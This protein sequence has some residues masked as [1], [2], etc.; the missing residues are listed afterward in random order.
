MKRLLHQLG[1][2]EYTWLCLLVIIVLA[3]HFSI[4]NLP[5][6]PVFD[7]IHYISD[8]RGV[9]SGN[10]TVRGEHPPL[11][12]LFVVAGMLMLGDNPFG[13]RFFSVLLGAATLVF[14]YLICRNLSLSKRTSL[15]A[16]FLLAL[17]NLT[18]VF[19]GMAMLDVACLTFTTA[20]FWLYLR[21]DY[22]LS[23]I[24]VALS[25]LCKLNGSL[26]IIAI[27]LH[28]LIVRRDRILEFFGLLVFAVVFFVSLMPVFD[29]YLF[30]KWTNPF[31]H[32]SAML[33]GTASLTFEN[34]DN[35]YALPPWEWVFRFDL[36]PFTFH[37][38]YLGVVSYTVEAL[39]VP[40]VIFM[41]YKAISLPENLWVSLSGYMKRIW[42]RIRNREERISPTVIIAA[43]QTESSDA[44]VFSLAWLA[45]TYF[46]W[47]LIVFITNRVTYP[48]YLYQSIGPFC[49][50]LG[51]FLSHVV[52]AWQVRTQGKLRWVL[53]SFVVVFLLAHVAFFYMMSP[54]SYW[55]GTPIYSYVR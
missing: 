15:L 29:L 40:T 19:S 2:W 24:M 39:I 36:T 35:S 18:F 51:V 54:V 9:I 46:M 23:G 17:E 4:I 20:A 11:A 21:G 22:P 49:I 16:V 13:W 14:F 5:D 50:G 47:M 34:V 26:A 38:N 41:F 6:K 52:R 30:H 7:E 8:A 53:I 10:E 27:F 55:W 12:K 45:G 43:P 33:S 42:L 25:A 48:F 37:P 31:S 44:G 1:K 28:W 3:L 32:I